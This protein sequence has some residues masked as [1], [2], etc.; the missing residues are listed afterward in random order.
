MN[1]VLPFRAVSSIAAERRAKTPRLLFVVTEDW[2]FCSHH[3]ELAHAAVA[4]GFEVMLATRINAHRD[5]IAEAGIEVFPINLH[6]SSR[7][8]LLD[9]GAIVEL[10]R[11]VRKVQP[12]I[13]HNVALKPIIYGSVAGRVC[14]VPSVVN[15]FVGL[16]FVF[17]QPSLEARALRSVLVPVLRQ[18]VAAANAQV[19][20]QND[21]DLDELA[22]RRIVARNRVSITPGVG[23]NLERFR[24]APQ[25]DGRPTVLFA[26]RM[27][28]DKGVADFVAAAVELKHSRVDARFLLLGRIDRENPAA[29]SESQIRDWVRAGIV[30][31]I[32]HRD[33][34]PAAIQAA[35]IV[36][37]PSWYGEGLPKIL[38]EAA[39]CGRAVVATDV[40][41]C[42][43]VVVDGETG[44]LVAPRAP[45]ELA[46]A[47][48]VL[49][50]DPGMRERFGQAA[51]FKAATQ[52]D[53]RLVTQ[54]FLSLHLDLL[55]A[56][57]AQRA[58]GGSRPQLLAESPAPET[59]AR[60]TRPTVVIRTVPTGTTVVV[61]GASGFLGQSLCRSLVRRGFSVRALTRSGVFELPIQTFRFGGFGDVDMIQHALAGAHAVV[62]LAARVHVMK[63]RSPDPI[64]DYRAV[65]VEGTRQLLECARAA[66]VK[67]VVFASSVKAV[68]EKT[69]APWNEDT[70]A[71]PCDPYGVSKLEAEALLGAAAAEGGLS[72]AILRLPLSYGPGMGGNMLRL[73]RLVDRGIPLPAATDNARSLLFVG[74]FVA[75]VEAALRSE[76]TGCRTFFVTDGPGVTT[77]ELIRGI[78]RALGRQSVVLPLSRD[79]ALRIASVGDRVVPQR[80]AP[81]S[82]IERVFGSLVVDDSRARRELGFQAPF[83]FAEGLEQTAQWYC[84][85]TPEQQQ[86]R[87]TV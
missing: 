80:F 76:L 41:G 11:L 19:V 63:D 79:W 9:T 5:A 77:A 34:M 4:S 48:R 6:R 33:D 56:K 2:Y 86:R 21:A 75:A 78:G 22:G 69:C 29:L 55:R 31:W 83:S 73:F 58:T 49:V 64:A 35:H 36:V 44:F 87:V 12:D 30:E 46:R 61:T 45:R 39:A 28:A 20:V 82:T 43:D 40:R 10:T 8:P 50:E 54:R 62:H 70:P 25:P 71:K 38:L 27:L 81:S 14:H 72:V 1:K 52:F 32:E 37:L 74:N 65:N 67:R 3:L 85:L 23:V 26:G 47:I 66:R 18:A 7:N 59:P 24:P 16:G 15:E 57:S 13:L 42:R 68:G 53:H 84:A 51:R 17:M 60:R